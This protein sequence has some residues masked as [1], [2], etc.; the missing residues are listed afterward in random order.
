MARPYVLVGA[1]FTTEPVEGW[2][3]VQGLR[4]PYLPDV[5][6]ERSPLALH[7]GWTYQI[8]FEDGRWNLYQ[9]NGV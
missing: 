9:R 1:L 8:R 2:H 6:A 7:E 5:P 3:V 4:V